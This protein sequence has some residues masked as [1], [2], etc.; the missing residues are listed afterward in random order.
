MGT[1]DV[2]HGV[3]NACFVAGRCVAMLLAVWVQLVSSTET[4][5]Q[6]AERQRVPWVNSRLRGSPEPPLPYRA[7]RAYPQ[8]K[9]F[10]P[11]FLRAEPGSDR[12]VFVDHAGDW[13]EPGGLRV[14]RDTA[15]V[16]ESVPLIALDRMIYG[17]CFHPQYE[18]NGYLYLLTNG[19]VKA[20]RKQNRISRFTVS[21]GGER[22][23][24][25]DSELVILE[26][27]SNGHNGGDLAFGPDGY[28]YCPTG[29][30]TS[31]SD[32][33]ATGQGVDDLLAVMLRLDVD[34]PTADRP[35]S[36]P[37]DNPYV[38]VAGARPEIWAY[39][40]RNPWRMA[41]DWQ[42]NQL[43][44]GQNGQ[45]LW[46]QVYLVR[47]GENYG[48]SVQEGSH[49]FY[50][51]RARGKE[52]I[53]NPVAEHHHSEFR[54]LTGGVVYRGAGLAG[55]DGS[56][57]YGDYSTG[58]IWSIRHDGERVT[59]HRELA[60]TTLQ[61]TGFAQN[62]SG[63]LLVVDHGGG[64]YRLEQA[65]VEPAVAFPQR[66]S[67]TGLFADVSAH[68]MSAGVLP[69]SV[70]AQLWSDGAWKQRWLAVPDDGRIE[71]T[72]NRG[73]TFPNGSVLVK[74]FALELEA[75]QADSRRWTETRIM[76]RDQ[77]EWAGYSYRWNEQQTDA[78]LVGRGGL[79]ET[80]VIRDAGA[81]GGQ[82]LQS[83]HYPSRAECMVCHSRAANYVLGLCELQMNREQ[84]YGDYRG[85]QLQVLSD[86]GYFRNPPAKSPDQLGKLA[87]PLDES[88]DLSVRARSYLHANCAGCHV[89]AG[90]GNSQFSAEFTA[91][92]A[93]Q[94]LIGV[95]AVHNSC[96]LSEPALVQPGRPQSSVLLHRVS[97]RGAG[98]M[99]P[100]ASSLRDE[101]GI[102]LL[103]RWISGMALPGDSGAD[104]D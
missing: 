7:V 33:L 104:A 28:L 65:A 45:D 91:T 60:D 11:V 68:R 15:E 57:I 43:W 62:H 51:E 96:G 29:D 12:L 40:F 67:E 3:G 64:L 94:K 71:Y 49:P 14:C 85:N 95:K 6:T 34:R 83:W 38:G 102:D 77:N 39:G 99:P 24:A 26:W 17:F 66:L 84:D 97:Q 50:L 70:N 92:D 41:Y 54:S 72:S 36:I 74:S 47:R 56:F 8:L 44:V 63:D 1:A 80:F 69:Y 23:V 79:D 75:G 53:T 10:K 93:Q 21:R 98:Q 31:D 76:V 59:E 16:S 73:W 13:A 32:P 55:L 20:E 52:P 18:Q 103:R 87:D 35:Y 81:A 78:E 90:G 48:W 37:P 9:L 101:R 89:E 46:E 86:L 2:C 82:R 25:A 100:L 27:D 61:I 88:L 42:S 19:P 4:C 30:G 22:L 5:G 58:R